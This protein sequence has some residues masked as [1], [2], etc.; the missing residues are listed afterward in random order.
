MN[1]LKP[2]KETIDEVKEYLEKRYI[3]TMCQLEIKLYQARIDGMKSKSQRY[4][5]STPL[6]NAFARMMVYSKYVN[7]FY[8]ISEIVRELR[9]NRQSVST[10]VDECSKEGWIFVKKEKN[11]LYCATQDM[12]DGFHDYVKWRKKIAADHAVSISLLDYEYLLSNNF[13]LFNKDM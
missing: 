5:N 10:M 8:T 12:L 7:S 11:K 9:T 6:R 2:K 13:T 1:F 3:L 4:F